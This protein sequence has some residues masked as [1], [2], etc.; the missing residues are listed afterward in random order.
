MFCIR[1]ILLKVNMK[2]CLGS[3]LRL[4]LVLLWLELGLVLDLGLG[5]QK[6]RND[7]WIS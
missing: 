5:T 2:V 4:I 6:G 1:N 7:I 3:G